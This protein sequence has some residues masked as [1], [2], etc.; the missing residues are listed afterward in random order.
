MQPLLSR[1]SLVQSLIRETPY[2][3][4]VSNVVQELEAMWATL[5]EEDD[6]R[7]EPPLPLDSPKP[8]ARLFQR[9]GTHF[10]PP[11]PKAHSDAP[12]AVV[13]PREAPGTE[14]EEYE[15]VKG[16]LLPAYCTPGGG[17]S[18]TNQNLGRLLSEVMTFLKS[19]AA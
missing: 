5:L 4:G 17:Q 13:R 8:D 19:V 18:H 3:K 6:N 9:A 12:M 7:L 15:K 11:S 1:N 10:T 16:C 2:L 14:V